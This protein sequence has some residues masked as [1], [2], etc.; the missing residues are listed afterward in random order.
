MGNVANLMR[1]IVQYVLRRKHKARRHLNHVA[2]VDVF[3]IDNLQIMRVVRD[4]WKAY[5]CMAGMCPTAENIPLVLCARID[6]LWCA[7][8]TLAWVLE[9]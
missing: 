3:S 7:L 1:Y 5:R 2:D 4:L 6:I 8:S 9:L